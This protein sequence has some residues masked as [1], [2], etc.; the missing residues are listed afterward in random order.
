LVSELTFENLH[1]PRTAAPKGGAPADAVCGAR[2]K[3]EEASVCE[4]ELE[5]R[6]V[7]RR[8]RTYHQD[9][10]H[11]LRLLGD[12]LFLIF[13]K[14]TTMRKLMS[15]RIKK[16]EREPLLSAAAALMTI[17]RCNCCSG[18]SLVLR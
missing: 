3:Q 7:E 1:L 18:C 15:M 6:Q 11:V 5:R 17:R 2:G 10:A 4:E 14:P 8:Q 9:V 16:T 13:L 12:S